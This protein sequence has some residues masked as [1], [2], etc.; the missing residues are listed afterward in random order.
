LTEAVNVFLDFSEPQTQTINCKVNWTPTTLKTIISFPVWTP[1]SYTVRDHVQYLVQFKLFQSDSEIQILRVDT[2]KWSA[3]LKNL[4]PLILEYYVEAIE[5]SVRTSYVDS[6][7]AS[8][9]PCS[10]IP[11]IEDHRDSSYK[12][13]I[14]F[15]S[16]WTCHIPLQK[17]STGTYLAHNYDQLLDSPIHAAESFTFNF[18]VQDFHH[19]L[20]IIGR[21]PQGFPPNL[22]EDSRLICEQACKIF[23]SKPPSQHNYQFILCIFN[24]G[25]G[26]LEHDNSSVLTYN[27]NLLYSKNGYRKLLQLIGHEYFHQWNIRRLRP[28][29]YLR[30][31]YNKPVISENLWFAEGVTSYYDICLPYLAGLSN[32]EDLL[33]DFSEEINKYINTNGRRCQSLADSS[34]EAWVKLYKSK[35]SSSET[36]I[37]YYRLGTLVSLCLD[38]QLRSYNSSLSSLIQRLWLRNG[39]SNSGYNREDIML[40]LKEINPKISDQLSIWL[41]YSNSLDLSFYLDKIGFELKYKSESDYS[42]SSGLYFNDSMIIERI[43]SDSYAYKSNLALGDHLIAVN[44]FEVSN[45]SDFQNII[46]GKKSIMLS[47]FRRG[48]LLQDELILSSSLDRELVIE[49]RSTTNSKVKLLRE[50]WLTFI[51]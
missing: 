26:G 11:L 45:K 17:I 49:E 34:K 46:S 19:Q 38:I 37:S 9:C 23:D 35:L 4:A 10:C 25:Y 51:K 24:K 6:S 30:Y 39:V 21:P 41:D 12:L 3:N 42:H 36:Q 14:D 22:V 40:L 44:G 47:Y 33:N 15:P 43:N 8:I 29:E 48:I 27:W 20:I 28:K 31:D 32:K 7:L 50:K 2:N 5:L 16:Y 18:K 13:F 1:G